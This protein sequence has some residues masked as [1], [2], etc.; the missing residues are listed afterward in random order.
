MKLSSEEEKVLKEYMITVD[1]IIKRYVPS[2]V[3]GQIAYYK[4]IR[5]LDLSNKLEVFINPSTPSLRKS[6][7]RQI[8]LEEQIREEKNKKHLS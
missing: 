1:E 7:F 3:P 5:Y 4:M 2:T 6:K 8:D